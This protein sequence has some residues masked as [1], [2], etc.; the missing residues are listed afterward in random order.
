MIGPEI[1]AL[2]KLMARLPGLGPRSARRAVLHL[3]NNRNTQMRP[4]AEALTHAADSIVT[5]T[6]CGNLDT[7]NPCNICQDFR[8]DDSII[9]VV[10]DVS[11]LWALERT[12]FFR[13][14]YHVLG[15]ILSALDGV[16]PQDLNIAPL[17]DRAAGDAVKEIILALNVTIDGQSTAHYLLDRLQDCDVTVTRLAHGIPVG[18]ELDYLDDGTLTTALKSRSAC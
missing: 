2:I 1:D 13:G 15:G 7:Q 18:G 11:D 4:L 12:Q 16:R 8:R 6:T 10:E 9:C 17:I 3:L 14:R 5:C